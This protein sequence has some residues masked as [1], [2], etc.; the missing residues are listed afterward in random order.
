MAIPEQQ[1][2]SWSGLG[3]QRGSAETYSSIQTA[4]Q[5]HA[6]PSTMS[7][8]VYLQGSYRNHTNI[9]GD[10]DVDI[11]VEASNVFYHDVPDVLAR[12]MSF[13]QG[14]Y[15]WSEFRSE[16]K[17]AL[18]NYYGY[19]M[20]TESRT[21]KCIKVAGGYRLDSDVVPCATFKHYVNT[22][23]AASGITFWT[24]DNTQIVNYPKLHFEN[25]SRKNTGCYGR[26]KPT[27]RVFKN[28]RNAVGVTFPSYFLECILYNVPD[29]CFVSRHS[30]TF[31]RVAGFL[32][33]A[34]NNGSLAGFQSQNEQQSLFGNEAHQTD[35]RSAETLI[36]KLVDL[37][38][39]WQ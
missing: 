32:L 38:E 18:I 39:N 4:L 19:Q 20:V 13:F 25:G 31:S 17:K 1:L 10:S 36:T 5:R 2:E 8:D 22:S 35:L 3:A 9:R 16:V 24:N 15:G 14:P 29:Y 26:Y 30:D 33:G 34:M 6:W 27:V 21:G 28:A 7:Y 23:Y 12:Q 37:W 11:V